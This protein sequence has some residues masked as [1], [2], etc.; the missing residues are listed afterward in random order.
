MPK[1]RK[2]PKIKK[3]KLKKFDGSLSSIKER[4]IYFF[5]ILNV[6]VLSLNSNRFFAGIVMLMLNV[7]SKFV[8]VKLSKSQETYLRYTLSRQFL[9]FAV[10]WMGSRDIYTALI[11][12][13][14]FVV[15]ADYLFNENS[16]MCVLPKR[17]KDLQNVMDIDQDGIISNDE[18]EQ[19]IKILKKA[20]KTKKKKATVNKI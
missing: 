12:T 10:S 14:V 4:V 6:K 11:L 13:A 7:G 18:L 5:N 19:A 9:I 8:T 2:A 3:Y 16:K 17:F 15:L 1:P 20:Q